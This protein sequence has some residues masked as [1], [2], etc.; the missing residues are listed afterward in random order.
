MI[1][2]PKTLT[3]GK[4]YKHFFDGN[5]TSKESYVLIKRIGD[6]DFDFKYQDNLLAY[7]GYLSFSDMMEDSAMMD[8]HHKAEKIVTFQRNDAKA[9]RHAFVDSCIEE[10]V[11]DGELI[12]DI[13]DLKEDYHQET[14]SEWFAIAKQN[15]FYY[16][17]LEEVATEQIKK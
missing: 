16:K 10:L 5:D 7:T 17:R 4:P 15:I 9:A 8:N 11:I 12:D 6:S 2:L 14:I 13:Q 3:T 1:K